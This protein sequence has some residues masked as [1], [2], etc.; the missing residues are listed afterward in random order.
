MTSLMSPPRDRTSATVWPNCTWSP[1]RS[2]DARAERFAVQRAC[3]CATRGPR[4]RRRRRAGTRARAP[5]TRTV[6]G[7]HDAAAAAAPDGEL[8]GA[9]VNVSPR[10]DGGL[11]DAE[12]RRGRGRARRPVARGVPAAAAGDR[13]RRGRRRRAHLGHD[14]A[15]D[16]E[17]EQVEERQE[18]E[19]Q[20]G[21]DRFGH[22]EASKRITVAPTAISSPSCEHV[23]LHRRRR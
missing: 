23:L 6:V 22:Y 9:R 7:E 4:R 3:R 8:V 2:F 12:V 14:D 21:E 20:D 10:R 16:A 5:A 15:H 13:L 17:Q 19:L 18:A 11:E 1:R